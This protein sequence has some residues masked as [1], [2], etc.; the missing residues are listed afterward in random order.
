MV[1]IQALEGIFTIIAIVIIGYYLTKKGWFPEE[2]SKVFPKLV[3]FISLPAYM[4]WN[5][6]TAFNQEKLLA[7]IY[8]IAVPFLSM[9]LCCILSIVVSYLLK[10]PPK[11]R[12]VFRAVFFCS[13]SV[14]IGIPV[15]LALFGDTSIPFVLLY[16]IVNA[17]FFWTVGNY[18][19]GKDGA[20][21]EV[22]LFSLQSLKN[23]FS[24]PLLGAL[25]GVAIIVS[26]ISLPHFVVNTT[27]YLGGM[28]TPLSLLFIGIV[29]SRIKRSDLRFDRDVVAI[30]IG[31]FLISPLTVLCITHFI[32]IPELMKKVFVIQ[33]ALPAMTQVTIISKFYEADSEY[34][35]ILTAITTLAA[36]I[37][38]PC[39]MMIL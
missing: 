26:N 8:G 37:V 23:I 19:I 35:A 17:L 13:N 29:M 36:A 1:F 6:A 33:A 20:M 16:F 11:R 4:L 18:F 24:P 27:K 34:A 38:I 9:L 14:F 10:V 25:A 12:G 39:Y 3:N 32:A 22:R 28:T 7:V 5:L 15:N 21:A 31:R 2:T 30:L